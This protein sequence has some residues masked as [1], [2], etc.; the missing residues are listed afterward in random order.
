MSPQM[1][2]FCSGYPAPFD[3]LAADYPGDD[4]Y[5]DRDF[6]VEWGPVFHRGRLDGTAR[7]LVLGQDP[8]THESI[9]RRILV[10]EAGQ[11]LQGLLARIGVTTSYVMI[12]TFVYSVYG[13]GGGERH[14]LDTAIADYRHRWLDALLVPATPGG[15]PAGGPI[16][17]VITLGRLAD[18]AWTTWAKSRPETASALHHAAITHPTFPDS[19]AASGQ[20]TR[21]AATSALLKNWNRQ[22]PALRRNVVPDDP[23]AAEPPRRYG[24]DWQDGDLV[25]IP[26]AD[27]PAGT[28]AWWRS[29]DS[30]AKRTG[31]NAQT[32]RATITVSVPRA[33]R[34]WPR[35]G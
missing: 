27:L 9:T 16:T 8:A 18:R 19:A 35:V 24:S 21:A 30:W 7:V 20:T 32:K 4:V 6:R 17:A 31:P 15:T 11:R 23:D 26:A 33:D 3:Q 12:N 13:Q 10:G 29:L 22:L 2:P 34:T 25:A 5:P 28:P 1:H 14:A